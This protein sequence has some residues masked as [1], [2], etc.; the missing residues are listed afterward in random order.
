MG[1]KQFLKQVAGCSERRGLHN[2]R[3]VRRER[4]VAVDLSGWLHRDCSVGNLVDYAFGGSYDAAVQRTVQRAMKLRDGCLFELHFVADGPTPSPYKLAE[5]ARRASASKQALADGRALYDAGQTVPHEMARTAAQRVQPGHAAAAIAALKTA[6]FRVWEPPSEADPQL[7]Y[8]ARSG[9]VE[10]VLSE[11]SDMLALGVPRLLCKLDMKTLTADFFESSKLFSSRVQTDPRHILSVLHGKDDAWLRSLFVTAGNDYN[12]FDNICLPTAVDIHHRMSAATPTEVAR[13]VA[14]DGHKIPDVAKRCK[15]ALQGYT[16]A[17][18]VDTSGRQVVALEAPCC[19]PGQQTSQPPPGW[20][21]GAPRAASRAVPRAALGDRSN[22]QPGDTNQ[23]APKQ[24]SRL[25]PQLIGPH[26]TLP[27]VSTWNDRGHPTK[28]AFVA[29]GKTRGFQSMSDQDRAQ[30]MVRCREHLQLEADRGG[31]VGLRDDKQRD[32]DAI[33][34]AN[35]SITVEAAPQL[36][37]A[38]AL[39]AEGYLSFD[40]DGTTFVDELP[41]LERTVLAQAFES[42]G[43]FGSAATKVEDGGFR[44]IATKQLYSFKYVPPVLIGDAHVCWVSMRVPASMLKEKGASK[45]KELNGRLFYETYAALRLADTCAGDGE[46]LVVEVLRGSCGCKAGRNGLCIHVSALC[47]A[48]HYVKQTAQLV[49]ARDG[50]VQ[51]SELCKW[52]APPAINPSDMVKT[53]LR[54]LV[55]HK[56]DPKRP[57]KRVPTAGTE[58]YKAVRCAVDNF[59]DAELRRRDDPQVQEKR[60]ALYEVLEGDNKRFRPHAHSGTYRCAAERTWG[61]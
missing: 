59:L 40:K 24:R 48:V 18:A 15:A 53:P 58:K 26:A 57:M 54:E 55:F 20:Q 1:Q 2:L 34:L 47:Q 43:A 9:I 32:A 42:K 19:E 12:K 45:K 61:L 39:P 25:T 60:K 14:A 27:D 16:T 38:Y 33:R 31:P 41:V 49:K 51:T 36:N 11:D 10:Y 56:A 44:R 6:G 23:T 17:L 30:L 52:L 4:S 3:W 5:N 35:G 21:P 8:L 22:Q 28:E 37:D 13:V 46:N 7:A 29:F 50:V